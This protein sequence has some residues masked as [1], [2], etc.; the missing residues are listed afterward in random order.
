MTTLF[1]NACVRD[2]ESRTLT[3]CREYLTSKNDIVELDLSELAL[4]PFDGD[5]VAYRTE[6]HAEKAWDDPIFALSR[7]FAQADEIVIGAP[8]WDL[9]FPAVLKIYLEHVSVC[10]SVFR[11]DE[12]GCYIGLCKATQLTYIT[13]C[14]GFIAD[15]DNFGYDYCCGLAKMFGI[16]KTCFVA[17]QGLDVVTLDIEEQMNS[18]REEL[19]KISS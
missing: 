7:Q 16:P 19:K 1:V 13:T 2:K 3:L 9:S 10:D 4:E 14:G 18:A 11:L 8:Y 6:K 17:A 15:G 12:K 5:M